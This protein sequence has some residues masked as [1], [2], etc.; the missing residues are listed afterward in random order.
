MAILGDSEMNTRILV[1]EDLPPM[2]E[3]PKEFQHHSVQI[4]I[5]PLDDTT[6]S[7]EVTTGLSGTWLANFAGKWEGEPLVRED[8]GDYE[9]RDELNHR[10]GCPCS[11]CRACHPQCC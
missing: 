4:F 9:H 1:Y 7:K 10:I 2:V 6:D 3:M 8:Q 11:Q 5:A